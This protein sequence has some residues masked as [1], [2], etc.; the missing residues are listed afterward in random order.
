M[1]AGKRVL[2]GSLMTT[3]TNQ[4]S[5]K[6][7]CLLLPIRAK[8]YPWTCWLW[9]AD[10]LPAGCLC[11]ARWLA[12]AFQKD[13]SGLSVEGFIMQRLVGDGLP[14]FVPAAII[15]RRGRRNN[16]LI[17]A[18]KYDDS[19]NRLW[20]SVCRQPEK[21][22]LAG[23]SVLGYHRARPDPQSLPFSR[24]NNMIAARRREW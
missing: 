19:G 3:F 20:Y 23:R 21:R 24:L 9:R 16:R 6:R 15:Q 12:I 10:Y 18:A 1:G 2:T 11:A 8:L 13:R 7:R 5:G 17:P 22:H 14:F 4:G